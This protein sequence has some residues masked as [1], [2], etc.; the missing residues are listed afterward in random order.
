VVVLVVLNKLDKF[1][2]SFGCEIHSCPEQ[3]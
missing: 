1:I 3:Y 2:G